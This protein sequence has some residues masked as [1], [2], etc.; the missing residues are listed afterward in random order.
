MPANLSSDFPILGCGGF[1]YPRLH[2][3]EVFLRVAVDLL[4]ACHEGNREVARRAAGHGADGSAP[5]LKCLSALASSSAVAAV[6][7]GRHC[8]RRAAIPADDRSL[9]ELLRRFHAWSRVSAPIEFAT[10]CRGRRTILKTVAREIPQI[11]R[12][13]THRDSGAIHI[14]YKLHA[15]CVICLFNMQ[16]MNYAR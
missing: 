4:Q 9:R 12:L 3:T 6:A 16:H 5:A 2:G 13:V 1:L 15:F 7:P 14:A 8:C 10:S 11:D